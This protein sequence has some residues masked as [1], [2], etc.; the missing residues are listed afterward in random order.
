MGTSR[1]CTAAGY[2]LRGGAALAAASLVFYVPFRYATRPPAFEGIL[3]SAYALLFPL[4]LL[5]AV[6]SLWAA[7]RPVEAFRRLG[8]G[9]RDGGS[10]PLRWGLGLYGGAWVAMGLM[11]LPSLTALAEVSPVQGLF[12]TVHM[13][14]QHVFLG[15][16]A[17]AAAA[18][19]AAARAV[20]EG[21]PVGE[22]LAAG[23]GS[24]NTTGAEAR[25]G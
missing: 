20:L 17:V 10:L 24:S 2:L 5:L 23:P 16:G 8:T 25:P 12:A 13:T 9:G 19:P 21:R 22:A 4:S 11:C 14:A 3:G 1:S 7:W 15:F 18:R 6:A